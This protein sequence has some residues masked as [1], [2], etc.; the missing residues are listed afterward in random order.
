MLV[1][2]STVKLEFRL[3]RKY[4]QFLSDQHVK[5]SMRYDEADGVYNNLNARFDSRVVI[6]SFTRD[7]QARGAARRDVA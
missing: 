6:M 4:A 5:C 2:Y 3:R 1:H 7:G